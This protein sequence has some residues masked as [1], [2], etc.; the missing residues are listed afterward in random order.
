M[1]SESS[2][3]THSSTRASRRISG[4]GRCKERQSETRNTT[5]RPSASAR[6]AL[7][8]WW[9]YERIYRLR[10][11]IWNQQLVGLRSRDGSSDDYTNAGF[12]TSGRLQPGTGKYRTKGRRNKAVMVALCEHSG[13]PSGE[14]AAS[15]NRLE[16]PDGDEANHSMDQ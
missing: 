7:S 12:A 13:D 5:T 8:N 4:S 1:K 2:V 3:S 14:D 9:S 11:S 10:P 16:R 15:G 6:R